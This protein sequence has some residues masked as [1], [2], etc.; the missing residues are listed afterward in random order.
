M[1]SDQKCETQWKW[2]LLHRERIKQVSEVLPIS[3]PL[4]FSLHLDYQDVFSHYV[5]T[6]PTTHETKTELLPDA[7]ETV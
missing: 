6:I 3:P 2:I 5:V 7:N 1:L 4:P